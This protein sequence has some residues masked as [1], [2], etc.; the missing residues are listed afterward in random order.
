M[1]TSTL[2]A[3]VPSVSC[4]GTRWYGGG[5][6]C[7]FLSKY[8]RGYVHTRILAILRHRR[9]KAWSHRSAA[10]GKLH[11]Y[12]ADNNH[13]IKVPPWR[14][15][16]YV[17]SHMHLLRLHLMHMYKRQ[18]KALLQFV[19]AVTAYC[20]LNRLVQRPTMP[21]PCCTWIVKSSDNRL[22]HVHFILCCVPV[23]FNLCFHYLRICIIGNI[24]HSVSWVDTNI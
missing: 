17:L 10:N 12:L 2:L 15:L 8:A 3:Y 21:L 1:S 16:E 4:I 11:D 13:I 23:F 24:Y 14:G 19:R 7:N 6:Q 5:L 18:F 20:S 22:E 9:G